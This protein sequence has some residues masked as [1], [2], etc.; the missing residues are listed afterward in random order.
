LHAKFSREIAIIHIER[1]EEQRD[2]LIRNFIEG[3]KGLKQFLL[4]NLEKR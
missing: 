4:I 2:A 3:K 1:L